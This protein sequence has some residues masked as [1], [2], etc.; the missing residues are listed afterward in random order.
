MAYPVQA[1]FGATDNISPIMD[2]MA[3]KIASWATSSQDAASSFAGGL[4]VSALAASGLSAGLGIL[5]EVG[6]TVITFM[7]DEGRAM[8][9]FQAT[10]GANAGWVQAVKEESESL[11]STG[12]VDNI[13]DAAGVMGELNKQMADM[14]TADFVTLGTN[15]AGIAKAWGI[16]GKQII[17][18]IADVMNKFDDLANKPDDVADMLVVMAQKTGEPIDAMAK[19]AVKIGSQL[20]AAGMTGF[21]ALSLIA[22]GANNG[23]TNFG[24]LGVAIDTFHQRLINPPAGF[25]KAIHTLGLEDVAAKARIGG[26]S[27]DETLE[28]IFAKLGGIQDP[29]QRA[30]LAIELFGKGSEK[31]FGDNIGKMQGF[32]N[33]LGSDQGIKGAAEKV[34]KIMENDG[35]LGTAMQHLYNEGLVKIN[36]GFDSLYKVMADPVWNKIGIDWSKM[37]LAGLSPVLGMINA[38]QSGIA[39]IKAANIGGGAGNPTITNPNALPGGGQGGS[40]TAA[41]QSSNNPPDPVAAA[42]SKYG[43]SLYPKKDKGQN[44]AAGGMMDEGW[45]WLGEEGPELRYKRGASVEVFSAPESR[46]MVQGTGAAAGGSGASITITGNTFVGTGGLAELG[47]L[48]TPY[49]QQESQRRIERT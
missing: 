7:E 24:P 46:K 2:G 29:A 16:D 33:L 39:A 38:I 28:I 37:L 11:F 22:Q 25:S 21:G 14:G 5:A 27:M 17:D 32:T 35:T 30:Q 36:T 31:A 40:N 48:I 1:I 44:Q 9:A 47:R 13:S 41:N 34:A 45:G 19:A 43:G 6:A 8:A 15:I 20:A 26:I 23:V 10:M 42:Q 12:L 4:D 49:L 3:S 18:D